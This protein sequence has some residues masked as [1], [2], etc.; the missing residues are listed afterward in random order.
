MNVPPLPIETP[1]LAELLEYAVH[2]MAARFPMWP[3]DRLVELA[4]DIKAN[5]LNIPI[6]VWTRSP[7]LLDGRNRLAACEIAEVEPDVEF[8]D[9]EDPRALIISRNIQ[10][11][12]MTASQKAVLLALE[13]PEGTAKGG[14]GKKENL[15]DSKGFS[16][17][18]LSQARQI[19]RWAGDEAENVIGGAI[20]FDAALKKAAD[21]RQAASSTEARLQRLRDG[22]PELAQQ[23]PETLTLDEAEAA[24]NER[25]RQQ[26]G[27]VEA[28]RRA[29]SEITAIRS[30]VL[31]IRM[32]LDLGEP[33]LLDP[34]DVAVAI[35][36]AMQLRQ[37]LNDQEG[38]E[39]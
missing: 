32:A 10:T 14:R 34:D 30:T 13:F 12:E 22:A 5:G 17:P 1:S 36:A 24:W 3:H 35:D 38:E 18:L 37:M 28:G 8:Y 29:L 31:N 26:R 25:Q 16:G 20:K 11:R 7:M 6:V 39:Q 9:G 27:I 21:N 2:P 4:A 23:V 15:L 19:V 33:L